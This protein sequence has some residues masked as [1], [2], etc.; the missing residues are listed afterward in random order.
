M[1]PPPL[2]AAAKV[3]LP[4]R[5]RFSIHID[6]KTTTTTKLTSR[7]WTT[8]T[9]RRG[10]PRDMRDKSIITCQAR[11]HLA[12]ISLSL[13]RA[14]RWRARRVCPRQLE[15]TCDVRPVVCCN[16]RPSSGG[17]PAGPFTWLAHNKTYPPATGIVITHRDRRGR[18]PRPPPRLTRRQANTHS[19]A[20]NRSPRLHVLVGSATLLRARVFASVPARARAD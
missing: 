18:G 17:R 20:I 5:N 9:R 8:T 7:P 10:L 1:V 15:L 16:R 13:S 12:C 6:L 19:H 14:L 2:V 4:L 3:P 11:P